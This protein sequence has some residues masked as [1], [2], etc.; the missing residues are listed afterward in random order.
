MTGGRLAFRACLVDVDCRKEKFWPVWTQKK[1]QT[2]TAGFILEHTFLYKRQMFTFKKSHVFEN[3]LLASGQ[4]SKWS[5]L[6]ENKCYRSMMP[7]LQLW[8]ICSDCLGIFVP[9]VK[10]CIKSK[11]PKGQSSMKPMQVLHKN[12]AWISELLWKTEKENK[13]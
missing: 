10:A 13:T 3:G 6:L 7:K 2:I 4:K 12:K 1:W 9:F 8:Q 5:L 11:C